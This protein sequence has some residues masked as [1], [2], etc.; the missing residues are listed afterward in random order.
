MARRDKDGFIWLIDRKNNMIISGGENIYPSEIEATLGAHPNVQDVAAIGVTDEK[1]GE[2]VHAVV[3][4]KPGT[5]VNSDELRKWSHDRL[6]KFKCPSDFSFL[7]EEEMPRTATGKILHRV[8][9]D[10]LMSTA[11]VD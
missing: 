2:V 3:V 7:S 4:C 11:H 1:W 8:L 10:R 5:V 9:R 6:A